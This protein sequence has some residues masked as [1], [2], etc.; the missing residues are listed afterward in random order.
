LDVATATLIRSLDGSSTLRS[1]L[2]A[3]GDEADHAAGVAVTRQMVSAG[4]LDF[5]D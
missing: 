1:T 3:L 4:F 5:A 2:A